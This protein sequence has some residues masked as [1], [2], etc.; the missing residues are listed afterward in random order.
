MEG[1]AVDDDDDGVANALGETLVMGNI[2]QDCGSS[3]ISTFCA[4]SA[5]SQSVTLYRTTNTDMAAA[6]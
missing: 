4:T 6:M 3:N 5:A 1:S 2:L